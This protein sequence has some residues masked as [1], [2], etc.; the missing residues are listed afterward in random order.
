MSTPYACCHPIPYSVG[1]FEPS[2]VLSPSAHEEAAA[3]EEKNQKD[4]DDESG[5][6]HGDRRWVNCGIEGSLKLRDPP[7]FQL[8]LL[9]G[10]P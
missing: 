7:R 2:S 6:G 10:D 3:A 5:S 4:D 8:V 9:I 1:I